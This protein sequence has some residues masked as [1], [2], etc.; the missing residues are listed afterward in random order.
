MREAIL[1]FT[2]ISVGAL[3]AAQ[4]VEKTERAGDVEFTARVVLDLDEIERIAGERLDEEFSLVE[5]QVRPLFDNKLELSRNDFMFRCRCDNQRS[6]A[7]S[8]ERIAGTSVLALDTKRRS[9]GGVFSQ[10]R[11]AIIGGGAPGTGTRPTRIDGVADGIGG[12][13]GSTEETT[14]NARKVEEE[15]LLGRLKRL[16]LPW[17]PTDEPISGYLY[18]QVDPTKRLKHYVLTYDGVYGEFQMTFDK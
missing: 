10:A 9:S 1:T 4:P 11:E 18:F 3:S 5:I 15:D 2:L 8:P 13:T 16:E 7:Q 12:T 17:E 6:E 14:I